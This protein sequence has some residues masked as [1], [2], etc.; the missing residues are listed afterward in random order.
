[1]VTL[2][3]L[4]CTA[5][6]SVSQLVHP[7]GS[8]NVTSCRY[9]S[10]HWFFLSDSPSVWGWN[11]V[12]RLHSIPSLVVRAFP[13]WD[14]NLGSLSL[15]IREGS[16]NHRYTWSR[17]SCAIPGPVIVSLHGKNIAALEHPWSTMVRI[18]LYPAC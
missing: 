17:Y 5:V 7:F 11:A 1:M 15:I 14:I 2:T 12:D 13:K 10:I 4:L 9:C 18:A 3:Q 16:P 6:A 8:M